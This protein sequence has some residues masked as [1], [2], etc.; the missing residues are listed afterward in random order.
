M[1]E[2]ESQAEK[3][4]HDFSQLFLEDLTN[5]TTKLL[6]YILKEAF[7]SK[8]H[9]IHWQVLNL[10]ENDALTSTTVAA[11]TTLKATKSLQQK[12]SYSSVTEEL[13]PT[14]SVWFN[15]NKG[16]METLQSTTETSELPGNNDYVVPVDDDYVG[17]QTFFA[18]GESFRDNGPDVFGAVVHEA[19]PK[20]VGTLVGSSQA[21]E[22]GLL[23]SILYRQ[24]NTST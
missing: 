16:V 21:D 12:E 10:Q 4:I 3:A 6:T 8:G 5:K 11:A 1:R 23:T 18:T 22:F 20:H 2:D 13:S 9:F 7:F 19:Q 24:P 14:I 15:G 17:Q